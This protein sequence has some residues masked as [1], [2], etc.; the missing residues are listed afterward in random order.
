MRLRSA[1]VLLAL[2]P[3][4]AIGGH[5]L[6]NPYTL[7]VGQRG[8][9]GTA[10]AV[11]QFEVQQ[12]IDGERMLIRVIGGRP[13][14]FLL[15][16]VA[17]KNHADDQQIELRGQ[18]RVSGTYKYTAVSGASRTVFVVE[19]YRPSAAEIEADRAETDRERQA[20]AERAAEKLA[21][22]ERK[23]AEAAR[24]KRIAADRATMLATLRR[25]WRSGRLSNFNFD[26]PAAAAAKDNPKIKGWFYSATATMRGITVNGNY[27]PVPRYFHF[28]VVGGKVA[29]W[30]WSALRVPEPKI[31]TV[32]AR[33]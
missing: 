15:K 10:R 32:E 31:C 9:F 8:E 6:I 14:S 24:E 3:A 20:A 4:A 26:E 18:Y 29:K 11:F 19:R 33:Y 7:K 27:K 22:A 25:E 5:P 17:T 16:G 30:D 28:F 23:S 13:V 12:V 1:L 2:F 21:D